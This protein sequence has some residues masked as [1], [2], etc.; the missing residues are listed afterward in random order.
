MRYLLQNMKRNVF[1]K[2]DEQSETRFGFAMARKGGMKSNILFNNNSFMN[3]RVC[4]VYVEARI[5]YV[6]VPF[7][8]VKIDGFPFVYLDFRDFLCTFA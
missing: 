5:V 3:R 7:V 6:G 4:C 1:V 8:Y 2:P